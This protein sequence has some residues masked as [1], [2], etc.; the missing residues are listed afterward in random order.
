MERAYDLTYY[1][2]DMTADN[3]ETPERVVGQGG[4][5]VEREAMEEEEEDQGPWDVEKGKLSAAWIYVAECLRKAFGYEDDTGV[6]QSH[7]S[8]DKPKMHAF[9]HISLWV[10]LF[11]SPL[12]YNSTGME[13]FHKTVKDA[14]VNDN[15][16]G[17]VGERIIDDIAR[18]EYCELVCR[19]LQMG[20]IG[21]ALD[22]DDNEEDDGRIDLRTDCRL[23]PSLRKCRLSLAQITDKQESSAFM[24]M[25]VPCSI[26]NINHCLT[27]FYSLLCG[28][29]ADKLERGWDQAAPDRDDDDALYDWRINLENIPERAQPDPSNIYIHT[30]V[31]RVIPAQLSHTGRAFAFRVRATPTWQY[32]K[33]PIFDFVTLDMADC[34][35]AYAQVLLL[36][37]CKLPSEGGHPQEEVT[38]AFVRYLERFPKDEDEEDDNDVLQKAHKDLI[39][40]R[41]SL[42]RFKEAYGFDVVPLSAIQ[43]KLYVTPDFNWAKYSNQRTRSLV[44]PEKALPK[45]IQWGWLHNHRPQVV[46]RD[47]SH[48]HHFDTV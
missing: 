20:D 9:K 36:F 27:L 34:P 25:G 24:K 17:F 46:V 48:R 35:K 11:G 22:A 10:R 28:R 15:G 39:P 2:N 45:W 12:F 13:L 8:F 3:L 43:K 29:I 21:Q 47:I 26:T 18:S 23:N 38:G 37:T 14:L 1:S 16:R 31:K 42:L 41:E 7:L 6:T 33:S 44:Y 32:K 19:L 5:Q 30:S 40:G 4:D